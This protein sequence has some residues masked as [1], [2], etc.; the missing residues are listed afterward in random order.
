MLPRDRVFAALDFRALDI[1]PLQI[2]AAPSGLYEH[3]QKLADLTKACGHDFGDL[4]QLGL[5]DPPGP[6]DFDPDGRYH[7]IKTDD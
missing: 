4:S 1:A 6:Q 7:A 3:G 5:P 2:F